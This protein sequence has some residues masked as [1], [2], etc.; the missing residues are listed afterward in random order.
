MEFA[1][2]NGLAEAHGMNGAPD[3]EFENLL[4]DRVATILRFVRRASYSLNNNRLPKADFAQQGYVVTQ[5]I[6]IG[7]YVRNGHVDLDSVEY[8]AEGCIVC[9]V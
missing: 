7:V 5:S 4:L 2:E 6:E 9:D 1:E 8:S 3:Q